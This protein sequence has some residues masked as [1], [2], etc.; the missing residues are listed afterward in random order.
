MV[1]LGQK[2]EQKAFHSFYPQKH[3]ETEREQRITTPHFN[4][5][6]LKPSKLFLFFL[7][8][9]QARINQNEEV[10]TGDGLWENKAVLKA[11]EGDDR[12]LTYL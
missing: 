8:L 10:T 3:A 5:A 2:G 4:S 6:A 1:T 12:C 9:L 7:F 11:P